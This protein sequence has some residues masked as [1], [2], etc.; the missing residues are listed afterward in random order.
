MPG[1]DPVAAVTQRNDIGWDFEKTLHDLLA[2]RRSSIDW[3]RSLQAPKW[4]NAYQHPKV[5]PIT[6][7]MI[8]TNWPAHDMLHMRQILHTKFQYLQHTTGENLDYAGIW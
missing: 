1:I 4:D 6:A 8:L 7:S 3:L 5:G 2:E